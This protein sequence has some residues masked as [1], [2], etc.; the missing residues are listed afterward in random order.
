MAKLWSTENILVKDDRELLFFHHSLKH[1]SFKS[2][3]IL[4]KRSIIPRKLRK[5]RKLPPCVACLFVNSHKRPWGTKGKHSCRSIRK[6]SKTRPKAMASIDH[7]VSAQT[8]ITP[9]VTG[10]LTQTRVWAANVFVDHLS[11]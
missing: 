6:P 9:Q 10:D 1:L 3:V 2:L 7:M 8:R 11:D 5:I 4:S